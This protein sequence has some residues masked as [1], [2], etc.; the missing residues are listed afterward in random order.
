MVQYPNQQR[1]GDGS[2]H[3]WHRLLVPS[4]SLLLL[5]STGGDYTGCTQQGLE[6]VWTSLNSTHQRKGLG[7]GHVCEL[8]SPPFMLLYHGMF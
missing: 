7:K 2:Q 4:Y 5:P 8:Q 3:T 6:S 1:A